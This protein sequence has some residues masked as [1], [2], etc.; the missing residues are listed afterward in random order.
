MDGKHHSFTRDL[1][2]RSPLTLEDSS[3][4]MWNRRTG[5]VC[6]Q[7][8][9]RRDLVFAY[10]YAFARSTTG[11]EWVV[12]LPLSRRRPTSQGGSGWSLACDFVTLEAVVLSAAPRSTAKH[13][14]AQQSTH[15]THTHTYTHTLRWFP[16]TF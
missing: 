16:E 1:T 12:L 8:R 5:H 7:D 11:M 6:I 2:C 15:I 4:V 9:T 3:I 14:T 10:A 13:S